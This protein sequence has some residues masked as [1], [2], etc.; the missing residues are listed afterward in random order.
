MSLQQRWRRFWRS[1][2]YSRTFFLLGSL[3]I[4]AVVILML[5][6]SPQSDDTAAAP[7]A[8]TRTVT[9]VSAS[10][11]AHAAQIVGLA[12]VQPRWSSTLRAVVDGVLIEVSAD[13]QPGARVA[14]GQVLAVVDP[15]AW[16]ANL[17][18]AENRLGLAELSL[19]REQQEAVEARESWRESGLIGKPASSLVLREPQIEAAKVELEAARAA[20]DWAERQLAYTQI[21]APFAGIVATRHV[22]RGESILPGEPVAEIFAIDV[23][24][25]ALQISET[26]WHALPESIVGTPA[27]LVAPGGSGRWRATVARVNTS[28]DPSTRMR[29]LHLTVDD[30]LEGEAPLLPGS[31]VRVRIEGQPVEKTLELPEG[32]L[33]RSGHVWYVDADDTLRRY[34]TA[35]LFTHPGHIYVPEP[36][37]AASWRIVRY[38]L[39]SFMV[40]QTVHAVTDGAGLAEEG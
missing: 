34:A 35:A 22:S 20:R 17:A 24:E 5:L 18:E 9:V 28:I 25:L 15:T 39:D 14:S 4:L 12:E 6:A 2:L 31:F 8:Q 11:A 36:S 29:T 32:V 26:Q 30:P 1:L 10:A 40:G 7:A 16:E 23:F 21:R 33:T 19:L 3:A 27:E 38:P 13:L 37:P